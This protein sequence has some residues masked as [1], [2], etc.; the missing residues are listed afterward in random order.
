MVQMQ[1]EKVVK[2]TD[3]LPKLSL[4]YLPFFLKIPVKALLKSC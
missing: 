1:F 3:V 4:I 2:L